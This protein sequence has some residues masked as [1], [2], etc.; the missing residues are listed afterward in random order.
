M[1]PADLQYSRVPFIDGTALLPGRYMA[2]QRV[3]LLPPFSARW[4]EPGQMFDILD[5]SDEMVLVKFQDMKVWKRE[6]HFDGKVEW[7]GEARTQRADT[8]ALIDSMIRDAIAEERIP[9]DELDVFSRE[10]GVAIQ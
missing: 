2:M 5:R 3:P 9:L 10:M 1:R 4:M 6:T 8:E 7:C